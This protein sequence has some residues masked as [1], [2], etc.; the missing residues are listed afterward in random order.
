MSPLRHAERQIAR[1]F[2]LAPIRQRVLAIP[3]QAA[4]A[5]DLGRVMGRFARDLDGERGPDAAEI[6]AVES[7]FGRCPALRAAFL[8]GWES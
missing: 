8:E 4:F 1:A 3:P 6:A 5:R 7:T 2:G